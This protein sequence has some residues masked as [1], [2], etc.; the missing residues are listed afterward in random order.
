M[1][2]RFGPIDTILGILV[3]CILI[4][5]WPILL[6]LAFTLAAIF[7]ALNAVG[8]TGPSYQK[9]LTNMDKKPKEPKPDYKL[10]NFE[11]KIDPSKLQKNLKI[12]DF[13]LLSK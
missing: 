10:Q 2:S 3:F 12:E 1:M 11:Y 4:V 8:L 6:P 7:L 13:D 5:G 9:I